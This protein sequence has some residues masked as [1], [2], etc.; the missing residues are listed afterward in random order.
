VPRDVVFLDDLPRT[1]TGKVVRRL[2]PH[3]L[4]PAEDPE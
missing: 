4:Q 2:L 1:A 3:P